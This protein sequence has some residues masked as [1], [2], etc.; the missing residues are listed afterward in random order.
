MK[1]KQAMPP[2]ARVKQ[3]DPA[4]P[5]AVTVGPAAA[6]GA[7]KTGE[8]A[9]VRAQLAAVQSLL[10]F[11]ADARDVS[12]IA[13]LRVFAVNEPR[14]LTGARQI[15]LLT[16]T[17][18]GARGAWTVEAISSVAAVDQQ[19]LLVAGV[20]KVVMAMAAEIDI[21]EPQ[22]LALPAYCQPEDVLAQ[23][24]PFRELMWMPLRDR[25]KRPFAG[26]LFARETPWS[27]NDQALGQR[28][29]GVIAHAWQSLDSRRPIRL[30][31]WSMR[32]WRWLAVL[33]LLGL[34]VVPVPMSA[35][36][37]VEIVAR[38]P[39]IIAAPIDGVI[40]QIEVD[41]STQV[42]VGDVLVRFADTTARNRY[43][44]AARET[45]VAEARL[46]QATQTAFVDV[47]GRRELGMADAELALKRAE[48][49]FARDI[50]ERTIVRAPRAGLVVFSSRQSLAGK[51]V[52]V[53]ERIME[54]VDPTA[55]EARVDL[56]VADAMALKSDSAARLFLD[57]D[58]LR[59]LTAV[60]VRSDYRAQVGEG[61]VLAFRT[62]ARITADDRP[63]PRIGL[64]GTAQLFG[65]QV[66]LGFF[67]F[68]RPISALRQWIGM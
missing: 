52:S 22:M 47:R 9:D 39:F 15:F 38:D 28:L 53:G 64:R 30:D 21:A 4:Q 58:P 61:D 19:S 29:A 11:E 60:V 33:A 24:Y 48:L 6:S 66:S 35:L 1:S 54:I 57:V 46:K 41:P 36:A 62:F 51:P 59:P 31:R 13:L 43:E 7:D 56:P 23:S 14:R 49:A 25:R 44:V 12:Q 34:L 32:P 27:A 26:L 68:R 37:P 17:S 16:R 18:G 3:S 20:A 2:V 42:S 67:L 45:L 40:E 65:D 10:K 63:P 8:A 50:L 5:L 55:V